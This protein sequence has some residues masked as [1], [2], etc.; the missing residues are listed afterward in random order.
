[1]VQDPKLS[2]MFE[3]TR[4]YPKVLKLILIGRGDILFT[5]SLLNEKAV[6]YSYVNKFEINYENTL[7]RAY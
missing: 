4:Q 5:E 2:D 1:M 6:F 7:K 3:W